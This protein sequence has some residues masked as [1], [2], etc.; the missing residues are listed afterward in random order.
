M[1]TNGTG[2]FEPFLRLENQTAD[3]EPGTQGN[4][5]IVFLDDTGKVNASMGFNVEYVLSQISH[6][7]LTISGREGKLS[8]IHLAEQI[9]RST[10]CS[11]WKIIEEVEHNL[12][13]PERIPESLQIILEFLGRH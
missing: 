11:E 1:F 7:T 6:P 10:K 12:L 8:P 5:S 2:F 13:V 9:H 4:H 3:L